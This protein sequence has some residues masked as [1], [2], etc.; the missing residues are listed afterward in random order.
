MDSAR[1]WPQA[2]LAK[3]APHSNRDHRVTSSALTVNR[4]SGIT[5]WTVGTWPPAIVLPE[6]IFKV[7]RCSEGRKGMRL[8]SSGSAYQQ[9]C[10]IAESHRTS[11]DPDV[12]GHQCRGSLI[13]FSFT[14]RDLPVWA[15]LDHSI[16]RQCATAGNRAIRKA[17]IE[18]KALSLF[19]DSCSRTESNALPSQCSPRRFGCARASSNTVALLIKRARLG[20]VVR[21]SL[22]TKQPGL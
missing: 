14:E 6:A 13:R 18:H 8:A 22:V 17:K 10:P 15:A 12:S 3:F 4:I 7:S 21:V 16:S 9:T 5:P 11:A 2:G 20:S 1:Q 19:V